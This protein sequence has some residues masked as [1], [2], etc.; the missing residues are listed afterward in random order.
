MGVEYNFIPD[1]TL[2]DINGMD[3]GTVANSYVGIHLGFFLGGGKR[4]K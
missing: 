2:Q 4:G 3:K 1:S